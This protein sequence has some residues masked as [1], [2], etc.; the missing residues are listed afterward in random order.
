MSDLQKQ[1]VQTGVDLTGIQEY[2]PLNDKNWFS[3]GGRARWFCEPSAAQEFADA[4]SWAREQEILLFLLGSGANILV[5]DAGFA[6]L[7]I[8]PQLKAIATEEQDA[9][10]VQVRA[11]AG[12]T[13][14]ELIEWCLAHNILGLEEFSG[15]PGTVGGSVYI[16]LHYFEFLLSQFL[17]SARVI[18]KKTGALHV[19]DP[20]WFAFGYNQSKLQAREWFLADATF[21]LR[22]CT[23]LKAAYA[24]GR[25]TEIIRH[26]SRRYPA[27]RTCGSFFRNF[28]EDEVTHVVA[29]KK[30]IFSAYYLDN[31]GVRD[32]LRVGGAQV[33]GQ[34][35]NMIVTQDG[36][37]SADVIAVAREMQERVCEK[38][39]LVLRPECELVG[40]DSYPLHRP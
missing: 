4:V 13:M 25:R 24:R 7:V 12:V 17:Y 38:Y 1:S 20:A 3:T 34:H 40:F 28:H 8:R 19:V 16:N 15:I 33:S 2:I 5:S 39:G 23:D 37:T 35:A 21:T 18:C 11:G 22:R 10:A 29:G 26:R 32:G 6:G 9:D 31:V 30:M 36:A 14:D 27:K